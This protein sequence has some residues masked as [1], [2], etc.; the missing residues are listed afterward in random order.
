MVKKFIHADGRTI[1]G[2]LVVSCVRGDDGQVEIFLGQISDITAQ[3]EA[4]ERNRTLLEVI[5]RQT[6]R[7]TAE[8]RSAAAYVSSILPGD[9]DGPVR[10]TA[11][12]LPSQELA[13]DSYDYRWIDDDHLFV[14][15]IDVSGHGIGPALLSV[16]VHNM[17]RSG[18]LPL[19]TLLA[20]DVV[21][22]ELN[23][24]FQMDKHDGNYLTMWCGV[25]EVSTACWLPHP[26]LQR[27]CL[28]VRA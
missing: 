18:S 11:R 15:L 6:D 7:L 9:L 2:D 13:G 26:H 16:S 24:R 8:L 25:Y 3:R 23:R 19:P 17:L 28:R 5:A 20:P 4:D 14:Y 12:Y 1:W 22:G 21:L 27:R 10:V